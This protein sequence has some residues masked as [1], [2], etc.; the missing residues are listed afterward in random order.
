M[1]VLLGL[2][3]N[4]VVLWVCVVLMLLFCV[5]VDVVCIVVFDVVVY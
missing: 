4:M 5:F 3:L 1:C 2:F